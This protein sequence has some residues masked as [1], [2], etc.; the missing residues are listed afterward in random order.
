MSIVEMAPFSVAELGM[1]SIPCRVICCAEAFRK[2]GSRLMMTPRLNGAT[3]SFASFWSATCRSSAFASWRQS[4]NVSGPCSR[5]G[6]ASS[7][8]RRAWRKAWVVSAPAIGHYLDALE[9]AF[10]LRS[11]QPMEANVMKR[12][13][14]SPKVYVRDSGLLLA[15]LNVRSTQQLAGHPRA[16]GSSLTCRQ[17][18][19]PGGAMRRRTD[20]SMIATINRLTSSTPEP[21]QVA[22]L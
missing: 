3:H 2:A 16:V 12:L 19:L 7:G 5:T 21:S 6:T 4:C 18:L 14:K 9:G 20:C 17:A 1:I 10:M 15:L 8:T 11:L 13:V 22:C